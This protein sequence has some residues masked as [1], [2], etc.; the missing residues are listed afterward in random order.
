VF[1]NWKGEK[2]GA[3]KLPGWGEWEKGLSQKTARLK[4]RGRA[5]GRAGRAKRK[6]EY[7]NLG[8]SYVN[9]GGRQ[10]WWPNK[11]FCPKGAPQFLERNQGG[12]KR[13]GGS[14]KN[15]SG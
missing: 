8:K 4:H 5:K 12:K 13:F 14:P 3:M 6:K 9:P 10:R 15:K 7:A 11:R 2:N 1:L